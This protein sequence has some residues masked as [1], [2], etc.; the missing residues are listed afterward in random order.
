VL[1]S[2]Q[3]LEQFP[4]LVETFPDATF[5]VTH[6]DPVAVTASMI[7][8][9]TYAA[10]LNRD[11]VDPIA[12]GDYWVDRIERML[13]RCTLDHDALPP[14]RT[15][16]VRFDEFMMGDLDTVRRIYDLAGQPFDQRARSSMAAFM[17]EHP[18]GRH[19]TVLFDLGQFSLDATERRD[20][21]GFYAEHFGMAVESGRDVDP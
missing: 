8:M 21:L 11:R 19:G 3:H 16:D 14:D 5:V 15:I 10:R 12:F 2:P 17:A 7:T 4:V 1:K 6:R 20:A 9:I 13:H 18:R